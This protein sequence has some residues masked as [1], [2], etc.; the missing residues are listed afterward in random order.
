MEAGSRVGDTREPTQA[1]LL[2]RRALD[3]FSDVELRG[4]L[5]WVAGEARWMLPLRLRANTSGS[6]IP[7]WTEW[8]V[9]VDDTYP[10]GSIDVLPSKQGGLPGTWPHQ[11][12]NREG[13]AANPW[14]EGR[15]CLQTGL[16]A[17][18]LRGHHAEPWGAAT[19]LPWY[20]QRA[21]QWLEDAASDRLL[22]PGDDFELPDLPME[23]RPH[24]VFRE[25]ADTLAAW[26]GVDDVMGWADLVPLPANPRVL[27]VKSFLSLKERRLL[28]PAWS[29][30]LRRGRVP[31][32]RGVRA[33]WMRSDSLPVL[34]P[35]AAPTTW[36][37][38]E[39][40]AGAA[41]WDLVERLRA[42]VPRL[43]DGKRHLCL[44]GFPVPAVVGDGPARMHWWVLQLPEFAN[45]K[46]VIRG[47][48]HDERGCW[49][50]DM[51]HLFARS[52][53][54]HW[55]RT[56]NWEPDELR[57]RGALPSALRNARV[58]LLGAG[59]LGS[60][61]AELL[62]R[63]GVSR[64]VIVDP[65]VLEAG[66]LVRH[67]L[68]LSEVRRFK[69]WALAGRLQ[70]IHPDLEVQ[71]FTEH[72][73]A[74]LVKRQPLMGLSDIV[75]DC[76]GDDD[77][78]QELGRVEWNRAPL[79]FSTSFGVGA[80]RLLCFS[81]RGRTFPS[82]VFWRMARDQVLREHEALRSMVLPREGIGCWHPVFPARADDVWLVASVAVKALERATA[83]VG[84][85]RFEVYEREDAD[86]HFH[87]VRRVE[88]VEEHA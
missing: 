9:L 75:V 37:E 4:P 55:G 56:E 67:T 31:R 60:S 73:D 64:L 49:R 38:L 10:D 11:R 25:G 3:G 66:N 70:A 16:F 42:V 15:L 68:D 51:T 78:V 17:L 69:A 24:V 46:T 40:A 32:R 18:G 62:V 33:L 48:R 5:S 87:G 63:G 72:F 39:A 34:P 83:G 54:L 65:E 21:R 19:R 44:L 79:F 58:L 20:V 2:G 81:A 77:V 13:P 41:G 47:Y 43:R 45:K 7:E 36:P 82:D 53:P 14:R 57:S 80:A 26:A 50:H 29:E 71:A 6:V 1:L 84:A 85:A 74:E 76:T 8:C 27:V 86:G 61:V 59:A 12:L 52:L 88:F 28:T 23:A 22:A 35:Y 30:S